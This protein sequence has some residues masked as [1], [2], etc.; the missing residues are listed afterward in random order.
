MPVTFMYPNLVTLNGVAL[1]DEGRQ[2]LHEDLDKRIIE[3]DLA[4]GGKKRFIKY[5]GHKWTIDWVNVSENAAHTVDGKG[6]RDEIY[7]IAQLQTPITLAI[8]D[9]LNVTRTYTVWIESHYEEYTMRRKGTHY[10]KIE[11]Q[12]TEQGT[13]S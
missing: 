5:I 11:L 3:I 9:G 1:T 7:T 8:T 4:S 2:P 6:G 10:Y 12:L 13:V